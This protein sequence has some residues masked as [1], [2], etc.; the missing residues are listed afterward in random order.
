MITI[1]PAP[2]SG[3]MQDPG[4]A[5]GGMPAAV[6]LPLLPAE[7]LQLL[8]YTTAGK[9]R[10]FSQKKTLNISGKGVYNY[11]QLFYGR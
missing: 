2:D 8:Y 6:F 3:R 5:A 4:P 11:L 1:D 7:N 10:K 9:K